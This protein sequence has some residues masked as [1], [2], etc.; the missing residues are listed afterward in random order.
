[1]FCQ[2]WLGSP[3][4]KTTTKRSQRELEDDSCNHSMPSVIHTIAYC[5]IHLGALTI[6]SCSNL[7]WPSDF[8]RRYCDTFPDELFSD[9][10]PLPTD[11]IMDERE[12]V[13]TPRTCFV[14]Y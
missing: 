13:S 14:P 12:N 1:M 2:G 3:V 4:T 8:L 10:L 5:S 7:T 9:H 6:D 11:N